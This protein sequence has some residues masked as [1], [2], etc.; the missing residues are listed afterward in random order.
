M[1]SLLYLIGAV[2][3]TAIIVSV[4]YVR[5]RKPHTMESGIDS[6]Q[7]ELKAL[8]PERKANERDGRRSG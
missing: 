4:L 6:F 8:S 7:R 2:V 1:A 3:A 5:N